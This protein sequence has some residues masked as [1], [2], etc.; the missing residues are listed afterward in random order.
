MTL[1][2]SNFLSESQTE[3]KDGQEKGAPST[4]KKQTYDCVICNQSTASTDDRP[5]GLVALLQPTSGQ[6]RY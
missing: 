6:S 4:V 3:G 5:L 2:M 1:A